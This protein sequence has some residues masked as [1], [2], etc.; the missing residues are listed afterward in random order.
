[1]VLGEIGD[2]VENES[3]SSLAAD[4]MKRWSRNSAATMAG[5][6]ILARAAK[7]EISF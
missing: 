6:E 1:M 3:I 4:A 2:W 5:V 7:A